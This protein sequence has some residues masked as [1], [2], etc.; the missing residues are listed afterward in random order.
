M[1]KP[2]RL[3]IIG[4][5]R[6]HGT[7]GATGAGMAHAHIKGY[8]K[9]GAV[10]LSAIADI[11]PEAGKLFAEK[12]HPEKVYTDHHQMLAKEKLDIVSVCTWPHLHAQLVIDTA[13]AGVKAIHCEKPM[14]TTWGDCKKMARICRE[15]GV[16][17]TFDHQRRFSEPFMQARSLIMNGELGRLQRLEG[18][19][20]DIYDWGTHWLNM[21]FYFNEETPARWV[22]SQLDDRKD[23]R[24]FG[25]P[26]EE[27]SITHIMFQN[28]VHGLVFCGM[29]SDI[30]CSIRVIGDKGVLELMWGE[31]YLRYRR[32]GDTDWIPAS[33]SGTQFEQE[34][35][36][37]AMADVIDAMDTG[38]KS[39]LNAETVLHSTEI[40][41][42]AYESSRRHARI[43]L[44]LDID[45]SPLADMLEKGIV[46]P[47][48]KR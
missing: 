19:C 39:L 36:D 43:D 5:G 21:F 8:Q 16:Q 12:Y 14:A 35:L 47:K 33:L 17:L 1:K 22:I 9:T 28:D 31:P 25:A 32:A 34:C 38:R 13:N 15:K 45:D 26:T 20:A 46:G 40:I 4:T 24:V 3:G 18:S 48:C 6:S 42:A 37:R 10:V 41:F 30:G 11:D 27:Q 7:P 2:Y 23:R 44:P 29:G